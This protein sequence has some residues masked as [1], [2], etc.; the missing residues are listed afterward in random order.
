MAKLHLYT[1]FHSNLKF[2][3]IPEDQYSLVIDR[4]YWP[5]LDLLDDYDISL[6]IEFPASTLEII[7]GIDSEYIG[8]LKK[9]SAAGRCEVIGSGYSQTIFPLIPAEA[10]YVNL[11]QGNEL[12]RKILGDVPETA[13]VN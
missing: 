1:S 9:H 10:N 2:S 6:G 3:S 5:L 13:L 8:A 12:Y 7:S 11:L 4:C